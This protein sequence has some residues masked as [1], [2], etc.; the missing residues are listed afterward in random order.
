LSRQRDPHDQRYSIVTVARRALRTF[1][2]QFGRNV[3][4]RAAIHPMT[5]PLTARMIGTVARAE[6]V[7][8]YDPA[9]YFTDLAAMHDLSNWTIEGVYVQRV[10][11]I[12][13][14][15]AGFAA[16]SVMEI[17]GSAAS[18]IFVA[19]FD[20]ERLL[21][22]LG[23]YRPKA[24][25]S[26]SLDALKLGPEWLTHPDRYLEPQNFVSDF[27]F[28]R[29]A[30]G[31]HTSISTINYWHERGAHD[32]RLWC[33]LFG[34]DGAVLADW[35]QKLPPGPCGIRL[36][37]AEVRQRFGLGEFT[38][39]L[40]VHVIGSAAHDTLK[41]AVDIY[42]DAGATTTATHDSN[43]WAADFY[44]GLPAP[45][46]GERIRLWLQNCYPTPIPAGATLIRPMGSTDFTGVGPEIPP[47]G[48]AAIDLAGDFPDTIWPDQF[49]IQAD[50]YFCRPRYEIVMPDEHRSV[51][52]VNVERGDLKPASDLAEASRIVGKGF[53]LCG[54]LLPL[55]EW[56]GL[57]LPTP[58]A[59]WQQDIALTL[60]AYDSD[61]ALAA[62]HP[63]GKRARGDQQP[64]ALDGILA[65]KTLAGGYG[66]LE[67]GYDFAAGTEGDG[68]LHAIFRFAR[69]DTGRTAETSFGS[70]MFNVPAVWRNEPNAYL[71]KPPGLSTRLYLRLPDRPGRAMC[72]LSYPT[73]GR[74][75]ALSETDLILYSAAGAEIVRKHIRIPCSG[76][77]LV[78]VAATF[79]AGELNQA[80]GGGYVLIR[81][82]TCRLFGY[83]IFLGSGGGFALDHMFGF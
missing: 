61:G 54:P 71:G 3:F 83:H 50:K 53:I 30:D 25:Q 22:R 55:A 32:T 20:G 14:D 28:F 42:D 21:S 58:M 59:T 49:E 1:D 29:D 68:W 19:D 45:G 6:S 47:Y 12:G 74:W 69:R 39:S 41:Y 80:A 72:H 11:E 40:F 9:G 64:V 38:G 44:A 4:Y 27:L 35:E 2:N 37:S 66:H 33:R 67:L 62:E 36:D 8:V 18:L 57:V 73:S 63:L 78:D 79:D 46:P 24:A 31:L 51:A 70:H 48:T 23:P 5:A 60:R 81:D 43:P 82:T 17:A 76:S 16:R 56:S 15:R 34:A 77:R 13:Q 7:A 10:E 52:H 26:E 75:R 65:G